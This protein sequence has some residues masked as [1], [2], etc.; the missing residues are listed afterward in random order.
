MC[1]VPAHLWAPVLG[2]QALFYRQVN[3]G[4]KK[5]H[6][7]MVDEWP[8]QDLHAGTLTQSPETCER[9]GVHLSA[10]VGAKGMGQP[11]H[12]AQRTGRSAHPGLFPCSCHV[13]YSE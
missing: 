8:G 12:P 2:S 11:Q 9:S 6:K 1:L 4:T 10:T 7:V 3:Q 13:A 5:P